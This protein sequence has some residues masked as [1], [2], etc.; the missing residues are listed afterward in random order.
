M[1]GTSVGEWMDERLR[2]DGLDEAMKLHPMRLMKGNG[3][4]R[5]CYSEK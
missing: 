2:D 5:R 1:T 4:V 3:D